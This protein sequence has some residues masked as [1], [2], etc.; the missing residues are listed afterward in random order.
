M[1]CTPLT[2]GAC[3]HII[4]GMITFFTPW[5]TITPSTPKQTS[6]FARF[7][8]LKLPNSIKFF[9][10]RGVR[11]LKVVPSTTCCKFSKIKTLSHSFVTYTWIDN[12]DWL[13]MVVTSSQFTKIKG[14]FCITFCVVCKTT[15]CIVSTMV[16][17]AELDQCLH[18]QFSTLKNLKSHFNLSKFVMG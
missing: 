12:H 7:V 11:L 18:G 10:M 6:L 8:S 4:W 14:D 3:F 16:Q 13:S 2:N 15:L 1:Q 5:K 17:L 9:T